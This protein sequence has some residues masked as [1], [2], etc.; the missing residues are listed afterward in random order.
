MNLN[1]LKYFYAVSVLGS[2]S[3]A[4]EH[5]YISQPSLSSAIK[6][7]ENEF[8]VVLFSRTHTGMQLTPEGKTMFQSCKEILSHIDQLENVMKDLGKQ[9]NKL[10]LGI[11]PLVR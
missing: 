1:Q 7:L 5:L 9:R 11:R 8:G 4:A 6:A 3:E 2:L 10:R